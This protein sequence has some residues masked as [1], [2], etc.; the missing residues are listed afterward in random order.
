MRSD[1]K[2]GAATARRGRIGIVYLERSTDQIVHEIDFGAFE[3]I[4]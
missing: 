2:A 4:Q 1:G 3:K